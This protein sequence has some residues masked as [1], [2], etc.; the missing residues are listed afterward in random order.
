M[1]AHCSGLSHINRWLLVHRGPPAS[2]QSTSAS[3]W[4]AT[5]TT[6]LP[7]RSLATT[8]GGNNASMPCCGSGTLSGTRSGRDTFAVVFAT[9]NPSTIMLIGEDRYG[10]S[11]STSY[12]HPRSLAASEPT[13]KDS[14]RPVIP[15]T[16]GARRAVGA[17]SS[18]PSAGSS[19]R[20]GSPLKYLDDWPAPTVALAAPGAKDELPKVVA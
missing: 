1:H 15:P 5:E 9:A 2:V 11:R 17:A 8:S 20:R 7:V 18:Y 3:L 4:T 6:C 13:R 16:G 14:S 10:K 19:G 12:T